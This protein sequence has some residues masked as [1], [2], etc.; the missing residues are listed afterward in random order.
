MLQYFPFTFPDNLEHGQPESEA[1][2]MILKS[3]IVMGNSENDSLH[4]NIIWN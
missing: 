3:G 4:F 2:T 1:V